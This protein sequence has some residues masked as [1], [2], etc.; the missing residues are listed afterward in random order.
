MKMSNQN[1][2]TNIFSFFVTEIY[3]VDW[4]FVQTGSRNTKL[5]IPK[6]QYFLIL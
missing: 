5:E 2:Y 1:L 6:Y 3:I 4:N